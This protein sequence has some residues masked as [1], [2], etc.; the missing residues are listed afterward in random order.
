MKP[1][2]I[3]MLFRNNEKLI[4]PLISLIK[5]SGINEYPIIAVDDNSEDNTLSELMRTLNEEKT[6]TI[7]LAKEHL[8]ISKGR[9]KILAE[10]R[11]IY[12][13]GFNLILLDSDIVIARHGFFESLI[14]LLYSSE[15][16]GV[17]C[18]KLRSFYS[19]IPDAHGVACCIIKHEV[20]NK[21]RQFD[22]RFYMFFDDSD[23]WKRTIEEAGYSILNTDD[24]DCVHIWGSTVTTGSEG[25]SK[26]A[27]HSADKSAYIQKWNLKNF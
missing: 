2:V 15:K 5:K 22:E 24:L 23:F 6:D 18:P 10:A 19:D 13:D 12:P 4:F 8:G 27:I 26:E 9:N 3:G 20:I 16:I 21:L 1:T 7:I 25:H 11:N 14:K 17:V